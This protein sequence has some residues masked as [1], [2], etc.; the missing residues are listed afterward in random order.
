MSQQYDWHT[1]LR[2]RHERDARELNN[3][4]SC[5]LW[6]LCPGIHKR[7]RQDFS[8]WPVWHHFENGAMKFD[9]G[10]EGA[11]GNTNGTATCRGLSEWVQIVSRLRTSDDICTILLAEIVRPPLG[12]YWAMMCH[13]WYIGIYGS[14]HY[15]NN[16]QSLQ[17]CWLERPF[18]FPD[19]GW[20][21]MKRF[22]KP[23]LAFEHNVS[24]MGTSCLAVH[25]QIAYIP[26]KL[27]M[28]SFLPW[29]QMGIMKSGHL[30]KLAS[31]S[32]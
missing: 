21:G 30:P 9:T 26:Y 8:S 24:A 19:C 32:S 12:C 5:H 23:L 14:Q 15:A 22:R 10:R 31:F 29:L 28:F 7:N 11:S 4:K 13:W 25:C 6:L 18:F 2:G 20:Y 17:N 1:K 3:L 27:P 16:E